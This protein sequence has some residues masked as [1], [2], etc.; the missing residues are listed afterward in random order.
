MAL[1]TACSTLKVNGKFTQKITIDKVKKETI[2]IKISNPL[3]FR[4]KVDRA[5]IKD[6]LSKAL[7]E[8]RY[9]VEDMNLTNISLSINIANQKESKIQKGSSLNFHKS[10]LFMVEALSK[11][12]GG[13]DMSTIDNNF[14]RLFSFVVDI[15]IVQNQ[16]KSVTRLWIE[17]SDDNLELNDAIQLFEKQLIDKIM[18][19]F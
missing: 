19:L 9:Q 6:S 16:K 8:K 14:V 11:Q 18:E 4:L 15:E 3:S 10:V 5:K 7:T 13:V 2:N 12:R 17:V 1:L